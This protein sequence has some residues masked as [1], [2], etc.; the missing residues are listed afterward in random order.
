M[1]ATLRIASLILL[2]LA[3]SA[4]KPEQPKKD[5]PPEPQATELRDMIQAPINKAKTVEPQVLD[6]AK[7][8]DDAIEAQANGQDSQPP[9]SE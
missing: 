9:P 4:C 3:G 2:L 1:T 5:Q 8:Q 6:A 7:Q